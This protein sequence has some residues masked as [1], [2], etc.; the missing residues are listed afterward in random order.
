[1]HADPP[2]ARAPASAA[3]ALV[4]VN[5]GGCTYTTTLATLTEA[6]PSSYLAT[7]VSG[8]WTPSSQQGTIV[9]DRDGQVRG[10]PTHARA[11]SPLSPWQAQ[12]WAS[13]HCVPPLQAAHRPGGGERC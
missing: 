4:I 3:A 7:L 12:A 6:A 5:V 11:S 2:A 10:G 13:G 1:M 9:I 8:R